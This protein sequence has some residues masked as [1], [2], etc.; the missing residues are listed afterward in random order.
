[1]LKK[2][3]ISCLVIAAAIAIVSPITT[4]PTYADSD[5]FTGRSGAY[6]GNFLGFT[7]WDCNVNIGKD[8][9]SLKS[10]VWIIAANVLTDITVA[11]TYLVLGFVIYG[12]YLYTMSSGDP[13]KVANGKKTLMHAFIGLAIVLLSNIILNSIRIALGGANLGTNCATSECVNPATMISSAIQWIIGIAG[14][15]SA[16]FVVY[17]GISYSTSAGDPGKVKK[18]KDMILYAL[19]GLII[20]GIAEIIT[21]F[22][23]NTINEAKPTSSYHNITISKEVNEIHHT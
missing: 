21:A 7:S 15:V 17:G 14:I 2:F 6:C 23:T 13:G 3:L 10:G 18:A 9:D 16:I 20:V 4:R 11:A 5:V 1:M 12:G 22:V 8:Q 19:I